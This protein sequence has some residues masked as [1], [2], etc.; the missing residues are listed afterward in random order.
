[1]A[2]RTWLRRTGTFMLVMAE[3]WLC[4][5][6]LLSLRYTESLLNP[7][8]PAGIAAPPAGFQPVEVSLADGLRLHGWWHA[9]R[10]GAAV[11]VMGGLGANRDAMLPEAQLLAANGY[12]ALTLE[13]RNC[14]G[15]PVGMGAWET[16]E[17]N[18]AL[19]FVQAQ[20]EV[21]WIAALG[22]SA[23]GAAVILGSG[24]HP[25]VR[26]LIAEGHYANL[27]QE[28][29]G[30][31]PAR[32]FSLTWQLQRTT[33]LIL[34][35]RLGIPPWQVSPIDALPKLSPRPLLLIFG[36]KEAE[37]AQAEVQ[38]QAA[39][40]PKTLWIVPGAG[41]GEYF[42]SDPAS[43]EQRVIEFLQQAQKQVP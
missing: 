40:E 7:A 4:V 22:F 5:L 9:S 13:Y 25:E 30:R 14:A 37:R 18:A 42:A 21:E 15:L 24:D 33:A 26:A 27:W 43:Y 3:A 19:A 29:L 2:R 28:V 34:W 12:G 32:P 8:C 31:D 39:G 1:M 17:F 36:E 38:Y 35:T 20:P 10:N 23:G 6:V 41:H 16:D 11:V